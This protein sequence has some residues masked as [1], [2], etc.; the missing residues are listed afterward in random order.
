M[1][2]ESDFGGLAILLATH[3]HTHTSTCASCGL[4][5]RHKL[6]ARMQIGTTTS[7][8]GEHVVT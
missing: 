7:G 2:N 3:T 1:S 5:A 6:T 4:M 8:G